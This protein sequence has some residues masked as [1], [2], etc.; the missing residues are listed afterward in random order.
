MDTHH[1]RMYEVLVYLIEYLMP[2][3]KDAFLL[4]NPPSYTDGWR[5]QQIQT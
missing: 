1:I 5:D 2:D 3:A 4:L